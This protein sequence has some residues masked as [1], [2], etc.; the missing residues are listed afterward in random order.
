MMQCFVLYAFYRRNQLQS[1]VKVNNIIYSILP[2][3][4]I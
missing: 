4:D 1:T 3:A 2:M